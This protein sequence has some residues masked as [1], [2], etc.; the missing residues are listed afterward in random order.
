LRERDE[1]EAL[2]RVTQAVAEVVRGPA[3]RQQQQRRGGGGRYNRR[4]GV[5]LASVIVAVEHGT[6][7]GVLV[8]MAREPER[9]VTK[10]VMHDGGGCTT[11]GGGG[12]AARQVSEVLC[13]DC[14]VLLVSDTMVRLLGDHYIFSDDDY[15]DDD[16]GDHP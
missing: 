6:E 10:I 15:N 2:L 5:D 12:D 13:A 1:E 7:A 9:A 11:N 4:I 8:R 16:I 3:G 14:P